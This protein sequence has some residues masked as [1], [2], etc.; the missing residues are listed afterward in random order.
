MPEDVSEKREL[1]LER[2][3][4][5]VFE[6]VRD[7]EAGNPIRS[8]VTLVL[9]VAAAQETLM[10]TEYATKKAA[11]LM[12]GLPEP[13]VRIDLAIRKGAEDNLGEAVSLIAAGISQSEDFETGVKETRDLLDISGTSATMLM[14]SVNHKLEEAKVVPLI[15]K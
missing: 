11:D 15:F 10:R 1:G 4:E 5:K 2:S 13:S 9:T 8:A 6:W 14:Q 3:V 12:T 7:T